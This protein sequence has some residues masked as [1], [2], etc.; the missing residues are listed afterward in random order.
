MTPVV[1]ITVPGLYDL[2]RLRAALWSAVNELERRGVTHALDTAV[3]LTP[4]AGADANTAEPTAV[5]GFSIGRRGEATSAP[6][7][8]PGPPPSRKRKY[9]KRLRP[10]PVDRL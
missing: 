10:R 3:F 5:E 7:P 2:E 9:P 4:M 1:K 8:R 6:E